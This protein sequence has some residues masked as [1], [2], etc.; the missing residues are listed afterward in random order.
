MERK[1]M[2][3]AYKEAIKAFNKNEV[4]VGAVIVKDGIVIAKG[5][6]Q[7]EKKKSVLKHAE[8]ICIEKASKKL[9]NWRLEGCELYVTL[10]P[11]TMCT[12]AIVQSRIN[13]VIYGADLNDE[14][15]QSK[16]LEL[17]SIDSANPLVTIEKT[18]L[19]N[20]CSSLMKEFFHRKRIGK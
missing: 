18:S 14:M 5:H 13:K 11:C 6:N 8:I 16:I 19:S 12:G 3:I 4:P 7:K 20:S 17:Y 10:F 2:E 1:Y 15:E 9:N